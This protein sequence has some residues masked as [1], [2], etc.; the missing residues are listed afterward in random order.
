[1]AGEFVKE[2]R[3][4]AVITSLPAEVP[5]FKLCKNCDTVKTDGAAVADRTTRATSCGTI[6]PVQGIEVGGPKVR[7]PTLKTQV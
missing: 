5:L 3:V 1:M 6:F 4:A 7:L 2:D